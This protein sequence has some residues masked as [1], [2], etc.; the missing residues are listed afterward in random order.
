MH[1]GRILVEGTP[2]HIRDNKEVQ[3]IYLGENTEIAELV[4]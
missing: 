3:T 4:E 2:A 1:Q